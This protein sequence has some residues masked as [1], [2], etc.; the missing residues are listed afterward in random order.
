MPV[1]IIKN[2]VS[3]LAEASSDIIECGFL[4]NPEEAKHLQDSTYQEQLA[5]SIY[6]GL[7]NYLKESL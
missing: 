2:I 5:W 6:L 7:Q 1:E 3:K 4:S